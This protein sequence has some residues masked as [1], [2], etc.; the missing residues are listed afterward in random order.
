MRKTSY[1]VTF[2]AVLI[3]LVVNILSARLPDW[4][5]TTYELDLPNTT[6]TI[7]YGLLQRCERS[8]V[9][10][11]GPGNG[12]LEYSDFQCRPFPLKVQDGCEKEN[13]LACVE[14]VSAR[15][16]TELGI[17][18]AS[19]ALVALLIGVSTHSR[20]R[21]VW[22]AV[23]GLVLLHAIFQLGAFVLVTELYSRNAFDN[24]EHAK[25]GLGYVFNAV[26]W[27][28]GF[29]VGSAVIVT[30]I[31]ADRGHSWAAGNRAYRP[32]RG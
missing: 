30:G 5:I 22:R 13:H 15:Y 7:R 11:P 28:V 16:F 4:L 17:G 20:R 12:R 27:V 29:L 25:P 21:R 26:S 14:W 9:S 2:A 32:I 10:I 8:I 3:V 1:V 6:T 19:M 24:F 31:A 23:A 18:F